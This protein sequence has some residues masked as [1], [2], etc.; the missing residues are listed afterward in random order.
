[1]ILAIGRGTDNIVLTEITA[2]ESHNYY[3]QEGVH[4]VTKLTT[5][6]LIIE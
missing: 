1:M 6:E 5:E 3:R 4:Y 2:N